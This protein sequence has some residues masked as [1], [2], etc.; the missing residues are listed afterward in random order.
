MQRN[1]SRA[2]ICVGLARTLYIRCIYGIFGRETTEYTVMYGVYIRFWPTLCVSH[3][4]LAARC[5]QTIFPLNS[6]VFQYAR[7]QLGPKN[8][9]F[10][11]HCRLVPCT[12]VFSFIQCAQAQ[13]PYRCFV[14][15]Q[16]LLLMCVCAQTRSRTWSLTRTSVLW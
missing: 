8:V 6:T 3:N 12:H 2:Y 7:T 9:L 11:A 4:A 10:L 14:F 15:L 5:K 1:R 13:G 16:K